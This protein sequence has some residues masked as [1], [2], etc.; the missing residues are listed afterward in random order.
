MTITSVPV[1]TAAAG[2][3][4][5]SDEGSATARHVPGVVVRAASGGVAF[6]GSDGVVVDT[7]GAGGTVAMG[8]GTSWV[9]EFATKSPVTTIASV[10]PAATAATFARR[11]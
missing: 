11:R 7:T 9:R 6:S 10:T 4:G 1:H 3:S 2:N 8:A 5:A